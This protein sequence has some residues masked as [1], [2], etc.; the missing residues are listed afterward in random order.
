MRKTEKLKEGLFDDPLLVAKYG[1]WV[2]VQV[3]FYDFI[4]KKAI[5]LCP[6]HFND[7]AFEEI[8]GGFAEGENLYEQSVKSIEIVFSSF[9]VAWKTFKG[10][11][12]E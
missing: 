3:A 9:A 10:E 5:S 2:R 6:K 12:E 8:C 11:V 4:F 1:S 7:K